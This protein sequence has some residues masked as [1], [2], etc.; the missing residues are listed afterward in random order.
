MKI[1]KGGLDID[2]IVSKPTTIVGLGDL[3]LLDMRNELAEKLGVQT[4]IR[5][6]VLRT[7]KGISITK[8]GPN[9]YSIEGPVSDLYYK[10]RALVYEHFAFV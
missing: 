10:V 8:H 4:E 5:E 6:G 7:E 3:R 1:G 2:E 9:D